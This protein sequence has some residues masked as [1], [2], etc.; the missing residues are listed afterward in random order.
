METDDDISNNNVDIVLCCNE[1]REINSFLLLYY[2]EIFRRKNEE[3]VFHIDEQLEICFNKVQQQYLFAF[4]I[5]SDGHS[6]KLKFKT[7]R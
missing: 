6:I 1:W 5:Y 2:T 3:N 4:L 7:L